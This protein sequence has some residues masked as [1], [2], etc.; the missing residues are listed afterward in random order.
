VNTVRPDLTVHVRT[1][2]PEWLFPAA[3]VYSRQSIDVG[4]VQADSLHMDLE[5]TFQRCRTLHENAAQFIDEELRFIRDNHIGLVIGDIPPLCFE[6]A[7]RAKVPSV[8]ITN[9]TWSRIYRAYVDDY[10]QFAPLIN[11]METFYEKTTL[12]LALP[13]ACGME[14]FQHRQE[15]PWIARFSNLTKSQARAKFQLPDAATIVLLSFG[16]LGLNRLSLN[17]LSELREFFFV[18]T[19][20]EKKSGNNLVVLPEMQPQYHDLVQAVDV[21]VT[22]PGYGIVADAMAHRVPVLYTDRGEFPEY[23]CL[24]QALSELATAE[25]IP[26]EELVSS[27]MGPYLKRLLAKNHYWPPTRLDGA[28]RAAEKII[29]LLK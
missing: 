5:R 24:V 10:P 6:I 2:A 8:A 15:I 1:T 16:G 28:A 3:I 23:P 18:A 7:A 13:Y 17:K 12:A 19:G 26:Q 11:E 14:V 9:F 29:A 22:K 20:D 21:V 27:N 4:I 25:F